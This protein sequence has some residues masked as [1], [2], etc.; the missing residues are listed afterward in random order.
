MQYKWML[1]GP[2]GL[3]C[4]GVSVQPR[5][6]TDLT[7]VPA[8]FGYFGL[9]FCWKCHHSVILPPIVLLLALEYVCWTNKTELRPHLSTVRAHLTSTGPTLSTVV[10]TRRDV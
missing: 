5:Q 1:A 6:V 4:S 3:E 10:G 2:S 8:S 9:G 7:D